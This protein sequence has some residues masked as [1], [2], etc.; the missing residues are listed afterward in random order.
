MTAARTSSA[1]RPGGTSSRPPAPGRGGWPV[2]E[3][4]LL[5]PVLGIPP[6]AAVGLAVG[7]TAL[8]V[9]VDLLRI[10]TVGRVFEIGYLLGCVLAVGWVRRRGI[11]L[12]A[13]QP[14]LLLA[15]VVPLMAVLIGAP[16]GGLSAQSVLLAGA[17]LINAFPAMAVTTAAVLLLT[18]FRL[19]RQ[20]LGPDDAVGRLRSRLG[21][22]PGG[23]DPDGPR[24]PRPGSRPAGRARAGGGPGDR[25]RP[26]GNRNRAPEGDRDRARGA[27][28]RSRASEGDRDRASGADRRDRASGADRGG[29]ASGADSH[30]RAS[31][32]DSR[33]RAPGA[34]GNRDRVP[35][36]S[37]GRGRAS[38]DSAGGRPSAATHGGASGTR[39]GASTTRGTSPA[40]DGA[41]DR[42]RR[43]S[44]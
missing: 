13:V 14:P 26:A 38:G 30:D 36:R 16:S 21:R 44:S 20:R 9:F 2:R 32:A 39:S 33:G 42:T 7:A 19:V 27:G 18:A 15:V 25:A 23:H 4:S 11:F 5:R 17:P 31:G 10:G 22:D 6:V 24:S 28:N 3:R 37:G 1:R 43:R 35:G 40:R 8:G 29:R 12:P 41:P 34:T